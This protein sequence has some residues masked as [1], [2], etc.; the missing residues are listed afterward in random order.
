MNNI[1]EKINNFIKVEKT[2]KGRFSFGVFL[3]L[4]SIRGE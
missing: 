2:P 4:N 1:K 3:L